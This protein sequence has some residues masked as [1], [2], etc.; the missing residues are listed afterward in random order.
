MNSL[1]WSEAAAYALIMW[2]VVR[3]LGAS[4][5]APPTRAGSSTRPTACG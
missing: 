5:A 3:P 2:F 1:A 4:G